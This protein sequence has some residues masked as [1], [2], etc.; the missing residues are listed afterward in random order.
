[1]GEYHR[2]GFGLK[3]TVKPLLESQYASRVVDYLRAKGH[4]ITVGNTTVRLAKEFGFCIGVE[5]AVDMAYQTR[6]RYPDK[7]IFITTEIIHNR[8]VNERLRDMGFIFL[9]SE[10]NNGETYNDIT[11]DDVVVLPAF[12][13][14]V[15]EIDILRQKNCILVDTTCGAV[16][17]VWK[18]VEKYSKD[19]F[20]SLIH[21][22]YDH[23]ETIATA[24]RAGARYIIVRDLAEADYVCDYIL[25][26]G[27]RDEFMKKFSKAVSPGFDPDTHLSLIGAANQTTMLS[28]ESMEIAARVRGAFVIKFG[29]VE[30]RRR[31][32]MQDTICSATQDRQDA[33]NDMMKAKP[34]V[35]M[36]IGGYNSSNTT[37]LAEIPLHNKVPAYHI[38]DADCLISR[39]QIRHLPIGTKDDVVHE[40]WWP[41]N[42]PLIVGVTAGASTPNSKIGD[43]VMRIFELSGEDVS[44]LVSEIEALGAGMPDDLRNAIHD[45]ANKDPHHDDD[46]DHHH[47]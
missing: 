3:N 27:N 32:R 24:S 14:S 7:R 33:V 36:V 23:E 15:Q 35:M 2:K 13:A 37:H 1:M 28:T 10:Y 22:K 31:F 6:H 19:E 40:N 25:G 42:N 20:T 44:G 18:S 11:S 43:L 46:D 47:H 12:G 45:P 9:N 26:K 16:I 41:S 29:D 8:S 4:E 5:R 30:T 21:G 34:H 39:S 17:N 38:E